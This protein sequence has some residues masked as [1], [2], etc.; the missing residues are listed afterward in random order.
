M[1]ALPKSVRDAM[2]GRLLRINDHNEV[3]VYILLDEVTDAAVGQL[4]AAG[5][6]IWTACHPITYPSSP[7]S[8]SSRT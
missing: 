6:T 5:V 4:T 3:Q 1:D 8:T 7:R 2:Q